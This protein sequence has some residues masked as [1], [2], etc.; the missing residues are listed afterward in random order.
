[1]KE[2]KIKIY[3]CLGCPWRRFR[4]YGKSYVCGHPKGET[5]RLKADLNNIPEWCPLDDMEANT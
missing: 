3:S 2:I 5:K 1:M 4:C